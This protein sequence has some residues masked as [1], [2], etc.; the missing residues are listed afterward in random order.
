MEFIQNQITKKAIELGLTPEHLE[1]HKE[2]YNGWKVVI[3][4][5]HKTI[6]CNQLQNYI[7]EIEAKKPSETEI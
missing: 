7:Y 2:V 1:L 4:D 3:L 5:R 6:E